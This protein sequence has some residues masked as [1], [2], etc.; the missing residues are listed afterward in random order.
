[1]LPSNCWRNRAVD[2]SVAVEHL[3][4]ASP[5]LDDADLSSCNRPCKDCS[6]PTWPESGHRRQRWLGAQDVR[7]EK[8]PGWAEEAVGDCSLR[9][10][11]FFSFGSTRRT[12]YTH[13]QCTHKLLLRICCLTVSRVS[14]EFPSR[15]NWEA[16]LT[17]VRREMGRL[18]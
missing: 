18:E 13:L 11:S 8:Q 10:I 1:M 3:A 17:G 12:R 9:H 4:G 16:P 15:C 7:W 5:L 14:P 2:M 6:H